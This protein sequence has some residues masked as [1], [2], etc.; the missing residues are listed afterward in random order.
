VIASGVFMSYQWPAQWLDRLWG[1]EQ[2]KA[3][4]IKAMN[5]PAPREGGSG[6]RDGGAREGGAGPSRGGA[7]PQGGR[8]GNAGPGAPAPR[9]L[10]SLQP[11]LATVVT[12]SPE[13]QSITITPAGPRDTV[14]QMAVAE[15]NT[16]R[17]DLKTQYFFNSASG[18]AERVTNYDS[19]STGRQ[20]RSWYRFAH[21]G[22]IFGITGQAVAT[23]VSVAGAILV[24][25]GLALACR[26][27]K[28]F[29]KR[30]RRV[31]E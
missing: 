27:L 22:E 7:S 24:Y 3:A 11:M 23:F 28:G 20:I 2:E 19:L 31:R 17:P 6:A 25:T 21:T 5:A 15:G 26:R 8:G 29:V 30:S 10:A 13:W 9:V 1:T 18:A 4:A 14:V 16:Y 12:A